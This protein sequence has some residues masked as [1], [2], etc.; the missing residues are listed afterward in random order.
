[1]NSWRNTSLRSQ[2]RHCRVKLLQLSLQLNRF[3]KNLA[4]TLSLGKLH[5]LTSFLNNN[6]KSKK[7]SAKACSMTIKA[8]EAVKV[9][10]VEN[11]ERVDLTV[12]KSKK[13][14]KKT[15]KWLPSRIPNNQMLATQLLNRPNNQWLEA[16]DKEEQDKVDLAR[17][18]SSLTMALNLLLVKPGVK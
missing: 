17:I 2:D 5:R 9:D 3:W 13:K 14:P 16:R 12:T 6:S 10:K 4:L 8:K 18:D 11:P 1:M 15:F 7:S